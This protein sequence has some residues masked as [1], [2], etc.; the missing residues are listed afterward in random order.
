MKTI[1]EQLFTAFL[2]MGEVT[3]AEL[4][5]ELPDMD[6]SKLLNN[7]SALKTEKLLDSRRDDVTKRA[8][9]KLTPLGVLRAGGDETTTPRA[10]RATRPAREKPAA[11]QTCEPRVVR[12]AEYGCAIQMDGRLSLWKGDQTLEFDDTESREVIAFIA[13]Q[14]AE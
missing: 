6:R 12:D 4:E 8:M 11:P 5:Q 14:T 3:S 9:Y 7:I 13:R 1:R 10:P 2:R